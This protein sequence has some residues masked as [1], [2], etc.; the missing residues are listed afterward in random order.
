MVL[1]KAAVVSAVGPIDVAVSD[2]AYFSSDSIGVRL[3]VRRDC[4]G[5]REC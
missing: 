3:T 2:Q 4:C 5:R 1:D